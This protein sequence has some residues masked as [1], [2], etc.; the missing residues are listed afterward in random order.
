MIP[1]DPPHNHVQQ[2]LPFDILKHIFDFDGRFYY[3]VIRHIFVSKILKTDARYEMLSKH[4]RT[5]TYYELGNQYL[6]ANYED[7]VTATLIAYKNNHDF[8]KMNITFYNEKDADYLIVYH[9]YCKDYIIIALSYMNGMVHH[10]IIPYSKSKTKMSV[11]YSNNISDVS[12]VSDMSIHP[13]ISSASG[14]MG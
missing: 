11:Y 6:N 13:S 2:T 7:H 1:P 4:Y 5:R 9:T 8:Y 12:V 14:C 3:D 10:Y